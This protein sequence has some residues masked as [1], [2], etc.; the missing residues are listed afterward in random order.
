ML[1]HLGYDDEELRGI[2]ARAKNRQWD[3]EYF[4][5][6]KCKKILKDNNIKLVSWREVG[7]VM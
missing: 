6:E 2:T 5:S 4:T 1:I 7:Q 3:L